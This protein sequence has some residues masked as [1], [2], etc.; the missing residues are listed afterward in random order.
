MQKSVF[1]IGGNDVVEFESLKKREYLASVSDLTLYTILEAPDPAEDADP[2]CMTFHSHPYFE[3]FVCGC[4]FVTLLTSNGE[5]DLCAGDA[6]L[7]PARYPH[8]RTRV[9][10]DAEWYSVGYAVS[11]GPSYDGDSLFESV[12]GLNRS[13][14]IRKYM[15][16]TR[17]FK[18][19]KSLFEYPDD[20]PKFIPA[21][22]LFLVLAQLKQTNSLDLEIDGDG[23]ALHSQ[24]ELMS[25][26]SYLDYYVYRRFSE[27]IPAAE[28]ARQ[29]FISE[30]QLGRIAKKRYGMSLHRAINEKRIATAAELLCSTNK[31]TEQISRAV[32]FNTVTCFYREFSKKYG[33][34][35]SEYRKQKT[36]PDS[37]FS[38]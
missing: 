16:E 19:V 21:M 33:I 22:R 34:T 9:S 8:M 23:S 25:L 37:S 30:R 15:N 24:T 29:L 4:G 1:G 17:I 31:T 35:P 6:V 5:L 7:I 32:G 10:D 13:N 27:T 20:T 3:L 36:R 38:V 28:I 26:L 12:D 14:L 2:S 11:H 18:D